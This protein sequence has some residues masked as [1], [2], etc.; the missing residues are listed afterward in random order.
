MGIFSPHF[1]TVTL[2]TLVT[3]HDGSLSACSWCSLQQTDTA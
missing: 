2:V 3:H 1:Y